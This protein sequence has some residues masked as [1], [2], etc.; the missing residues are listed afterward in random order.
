MPRASLKHLPC[1]VLVLFIRSQGEW[2]LLDFNS[3][4]FLV[5]I[6][7]RQEIAPSGNRRFFAALGSGEVCDRSDR[8]AGFSLTSKA[9]KTR[10]IRRDCRLNPSLTP[11]APRNGWLRSFGKPDPRRGSACVVV[12]R[13]RD[14]DAYYVSV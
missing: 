8:W 12:T 3:R 10:G 6:H 14:G 1:Q 2:S 7:N 13:K 11:F 9:R 4:P 5:L